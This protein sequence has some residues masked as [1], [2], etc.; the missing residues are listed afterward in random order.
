MNSR[1]KKLSKLLVLLLSSLMIGVASA[2]TY[3]MFMN[4]TVGVATTGMSFVANP[5]HFATCGGIITDNNQK[6]TFT[7]MNGPAGSEAVWT[8]LQIH[9]D[10]SL[11]DSIELKLDTWT[12][13]SQTNLY[14]IKVTMYNGAA[15]QG[16]TIVL[17]PTSEGISV[18]T[19]GSVP[20]ANGDAWT[21][22]WKV[23]WKGTALSP[24][25]NVQVSLILAVVG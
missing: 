20:M 14:Y 2:Y 9:C 24:T 15:Q 4:A 8:P 6:V 11:G 17:Y 18:T 12:G 25:D 23:Y 1:N 7:T 16:A 22:Q 19:T 21:V 13:D 5:P 10:D 3:N